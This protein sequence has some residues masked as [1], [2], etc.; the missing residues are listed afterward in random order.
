[1][2]ADP[3]EALKPAPWQRV[4][5]LQGPVGP[6]FRLIRKYLK[7]L[8]LH[9]WQVLFNPGDRLFAGT[10]VGTLVY[11]GGADGLE[12]WLCAQA[13]ARKITHMVLFG[14]ER[15]V[16]ITARR[17]AA[18][19]GIIVISLEEGYIRPG[20]ITVE[21]GANNAFSPIAG[22]LPPRS[23]R[24]D[25]EGAYT[26]NAGHFSAMCIYGGLYYGAIA[27]FAKR[28]QRQLLHRDI[29]VFQEMP[30]WIKNF[31]RWCWG[32][33]RNGAIIER[34][35]EHDVGQY[36]VVALQVSQDSQLKHAARGWNNARLI[37][38]VLD[39]FALSAPQR[40]RLVFKIHPLERG[41]DKDRALIEELAIKLGIRHRVDIVDVGSI[42]SLTRHSAGMIT[43]NSTSGFSAIYH[44][45][46]LL[47]IG[48]A[49]YANENIAT[50]AFG[51]PDLDAFWKGGLVDHARV[52]KR[53]IAW[54]RARCLRPGDFFTTG[55]IKA[56]CKAIYNAIDTSGVQHNDMRNAA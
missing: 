29:S 46:P 20:A 14:S 37:T 12:D 47:V 27:L 52:R 32:Q 13:I 34:L 44:G 50:C 31:H 11:R 4:L 1:M 19:L 56:S 36:F 3:K 41:D 42:G 35:L 26:A 30:R 49:V 9:C 15:P 21:L 2:R 33:S 45:V 22:Q 53:Y 54:I 51:A 38:E 39:S 55:G 28:R 5:L 48:D 23:F 6:A 18:R 17:T 10:W 43:I 16:H 24:T 25:F 8:G 7:Q 40:L